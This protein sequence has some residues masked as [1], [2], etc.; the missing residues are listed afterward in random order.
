MKCLSGINT[1]RGEISY[2][3]YQGGEKEGGGR[4]RERE[5]GEKA[6]K[7]EEGSYKPL[8]I[9]SPTHHK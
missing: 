1:G 9:P 7:E 2:T 6:V 8:L 3:N 5:K 4:Q